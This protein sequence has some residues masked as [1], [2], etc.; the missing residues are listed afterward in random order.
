L[1]QRRLPCARRTPQ[2][3]G[4]KQSVRFDGAAQELAFTDDVFLPTYSSSARTH[5]ASGA[6]CSYVPAW[7]G[8][9]DQT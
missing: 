6:S 4:R 3:D 7:R 8:R 2:N 1:C 5:T 9:K